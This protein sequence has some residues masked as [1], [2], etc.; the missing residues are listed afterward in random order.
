ML[1]IEI[2]QNAGV[3]Q[4]IFH[5]RDLVRLSDGSPTK[6]Y[7]QVHHALAKGYLMRL[8]RGAYIVAPKYRTVKV[9]KFVVAG[10]MVP[11]SYISFESALS[12]HGWIPERVVQVSSVILKGRPRHFETPL[13][14]FG[15]EYVHLPVKESE[16]LTGVTREE[17]QGQPF[18]MATPLRALVDYV[19]DRKIEWTSIDWLLEGLRIEEENL[20]TLTLAD[21]QQVRSVFRARRVLAFL[22]GIQ[23]ELFATTTSYQR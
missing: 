1:I 20:R 9:S 11:N 14:D 13:G 22:N 17:Y 2:L 21:F 6:C 4:R 16:F 3:H 8:Q 19:Y 15:F 23:R 7:R 10:Q 5:A 18:L 12:Y